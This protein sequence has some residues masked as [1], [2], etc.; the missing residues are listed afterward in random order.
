MQTQ[1]VENIDRDAVAH[2]AYEL[3]VAGGKKEGVAE[4]NWIEAERIVRESTTLKVASVARKSDPP[5]APR[6]SSSP[7][8]ANISSA[9]NGKK[10]N[11]R[12]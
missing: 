6:A 2:K 5:S 7:P 9:S 4:Q 11:K 1:T 3:W 10:A 8:V 12:H